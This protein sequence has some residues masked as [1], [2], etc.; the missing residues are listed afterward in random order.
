MREREARFEDIMKRLGKMP[1]VMANR[2]MELEDRVRELQD[3]ME[4]AALG[5]MNAA[6]RQK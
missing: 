3:E 4:R 1:G 2:I 6:K 5:L